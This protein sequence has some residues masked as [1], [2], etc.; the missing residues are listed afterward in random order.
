MA[1]TPWR[2]C[3]TQCDPPPPPP[4]KNPGYAPDQAQNSTGETA[5]SKRVVVIFILFLAVSKSTYRG[6][7]SYVSV[8][9]KG[10]RIYARQ[11]PMISANNVASDRNNTEQNGTKQK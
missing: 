9:N 10:G 6:C 4:L 1:K 5:R 7:P 3:L 11:E 8:V 2:Y